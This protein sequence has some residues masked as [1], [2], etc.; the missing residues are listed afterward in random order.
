MEINVKT[1][2]LRLEEEKNPN[3]GSNNKNKYPKIMPEGSKAYHVCKDASMESE[4]L[5]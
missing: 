1:S 2:K 5:E 4:N 3:L